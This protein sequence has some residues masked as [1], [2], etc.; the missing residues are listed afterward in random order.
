MINLEKRH[1][2]QIIFVSYIPLYYLEGNKSNEVPNTL[3]QR[4]HPALSA[5]DLKLVEE[6]KKASRVE[7]FG[8]Y[9]PIPEHM[10][11]QIV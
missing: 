11:A 2:H 3:F 8:S 6:K 10:Y 9:F 7:T 1:Y 4:K 5:P